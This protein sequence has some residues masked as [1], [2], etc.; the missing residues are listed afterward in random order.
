MTGQPALP[1]SWPCENESNI[2][3]WYSVQ[4][5]SQL[6]FV[7]TIFHDWHHLS[8]YLK[9][10]RRLVKGWLRIF[11]WGEGDEYSTADKNSTLMDFDYFH[12]FSWE[13]KLMEIFHY[14]WIHT[15]L[16]KDLFAHDSFRR[17]HLCQKLIFRSVPRTFWMSPFAT[18]DYRQLP[19]VSMFAQKNHSQMR[20]K[21]CARASRIYQS[22]FSAPK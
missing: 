16:V 11:F 8:N 14:Y 10:T 7:K 6:S 3:F 22:K 20:N 15:N 21:N 4:K 12:V 17:L 2:I 5:T 1:P 19:Q 18:A 13:G 9:A